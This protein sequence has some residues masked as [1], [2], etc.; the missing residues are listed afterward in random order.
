M[1]N[2]NKK[3]EK[4]K[5]PQPILNTFDDLFALKN[6]LRINTPTKIEHKIKKGT[7]RKSE[8]KFSETSCKVKRKR[9]LSKTPIPDPSI[10]PNIQPNIQ[11]SQKIIPESLKDEIIEISSSRNSHSSLQIQVSTPPNEEPDMFDSNQFDPDITLTPTTSETSIEK[12]LLK[13]YNK[14][15]GKLDTEKLTHAEAWSEE[16]YGEIRFSL[17]EEMIKNLRKPPHNINFDE[18]DTFLDLGSGIGQVPL[19]VAAST[20][21]G[22]SYGIEKEVYRSQQANNFRK[23]LDKNLSVNG[24]N[25]S[26]CKLHQG[27]FLDERGKKLIAK[28]NIVL[29]NNFIFGAKLNHELTI[30]FHELCK[31]GTKIITSKRLTTGG[32]LNARNAGTFEAVVDVEELCRGNVSWTSSKISLFVHTVNFGK[33]EDYMKTL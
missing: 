8:S 31:P 26:K 30:L 25:M 10:Q 14:T 17:V 3:P 20:K 12:I 22:K 32:E 2:T 24:I 13:C 18:S 19:Q 27:D 6:S 33:L 15:M 23:R 7:K 16:V 28:S 11:T 4:P 5:H 21:T 9:V 29:A 1:K